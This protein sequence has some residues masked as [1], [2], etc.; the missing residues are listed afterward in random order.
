ME[1]LELPISNFMTNDIIFVGVDTLMSEVDNIF[2]TKSFH[3]LPVLDEENR[4]IGII[5]KT[6]YC[7][8]LNHFT[9]KKKGDYERS[10]RVY[11]RSLRAEDIM[12]KDPVCIK[13]DR[14]ISE[15]LDYFL[16]NNHRSLIVIN[17]R[18]FCVGICTPLDILKWLKFSNAKLRKQIV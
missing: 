14:P 11:F 13:S 5:S 6:D 4:P 17:D 1:N 12:T 15:A 7:T 10:N 18:G 16:E 2:Q 9:L 3:N 8:L